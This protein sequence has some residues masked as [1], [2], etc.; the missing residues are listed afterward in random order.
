MF[1]FEQTG[2]MTARRE[3]EDVGEEEAKED[4]E[5]TN[6]SSLTT[7]PQCNSHMRTA[8]WGISRCGNC[9]FKLDCCS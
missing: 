8:I 3:I 4:E 7:C 2:F 5:Q 1:S 9:G 6:K